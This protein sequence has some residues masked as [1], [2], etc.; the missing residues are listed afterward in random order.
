MALLILLAPYILI[1]SIIIVLILIFVKRSLYKLLLSIAACTGMWLFLFVDTIP[2]RIKFNELCEKYA[3][4]HVFETVEIG[5]EYFNKGKLNIKKLEIDST[6]TVEHK[7][8]NSIS[9]KYNIG[10]T[11][12]IYKVNDIKVAEYI[13]YNYRPGKT[14]GKGSGGGKSCLNNIFNEEL[15]VLVFKEKVK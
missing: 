13:N 12:F 2:A 10:I 7:S 3:G 4:I 5:G 14:F 8:K 9:E 11:N 6:F 1:L 15:L